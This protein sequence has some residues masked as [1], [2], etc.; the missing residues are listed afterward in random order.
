MKVYL[1]LGDF[2]AR[3]TTNQIIILSNNSNPNPL[4]LYE[5]LVLASKY[6]RNSGDLVNILFDTE[7]MKLCSS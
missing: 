5:N 7:V 4:W 1:L 2:N 3:T 6:K